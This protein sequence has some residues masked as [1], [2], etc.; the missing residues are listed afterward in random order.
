MYLGKRRDKFTFTRGSFP[1]GKAAWPY[2]HS[3]HYVV[4]FKEY[5]ELYLHSPLRLHG[6]VL[7]QHRDFTLLKLSLCL[8]KHHTVKAYWGVEV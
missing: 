8:T 1:E 6:M 4:E 5:V 7:V 3:P 2:D